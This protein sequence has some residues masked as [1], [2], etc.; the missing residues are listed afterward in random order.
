M[1]LIP[2]PDTRFSQLKNVMF[3]MSFLG[4]VRNFKLYHFRCVY[5]KSH[6]VVIFWHP[7]DDNFVDNLV[8]LTFYWSKTMEREKVR[9]KITTSCEY[10]RESCPKVVKKWLSK[11]HFSKSYGCFSKQTES[12]MLSHGYNSKKSLFPRFN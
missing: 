9:E 12:W 1:T 6:K 7:F 4:H 11:Y 2:L 8:F 3:S 5:V 10:E